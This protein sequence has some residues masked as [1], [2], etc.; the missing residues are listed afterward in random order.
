MMT[1]NTH[2]NK[3]I[4]SNVPEGESARVISVGIQNGKPVAA[5]EKVQ[6]SKNIL[7]NLKFEDTSPAAFK[8]EV[9]GFD[10]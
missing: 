7:T 2:G 1:G 4:F 3:I 10:K 8:E 5:I 6:L 9:K